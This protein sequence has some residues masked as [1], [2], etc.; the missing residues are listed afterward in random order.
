M[1]QKHHNKWP[2]QKIEKASKKMLIW[3]KI[4]LVDGIKKC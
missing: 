2:T 4:V 1:A 3:G